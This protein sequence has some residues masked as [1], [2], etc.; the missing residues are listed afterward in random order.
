MPDTCIVQITA[1]RS[2]IRLVEE[3]LYELGNQIWAGRLRLRRLEVVVGGDPSDYEALEALVVEPRGLGKMGRA[4][5]LLRR[6]R[7][8]K[9]WR[10]CDEASVEL[11]VRCAE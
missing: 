7:P 11:A 4:R 2:R 1:C 8:V 5:D 6:Q 3:E 10:L 9:L